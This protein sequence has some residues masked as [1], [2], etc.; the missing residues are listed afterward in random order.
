M[1]SS[2]KGELKVPFP[3]CFLGYGWYQGCGET[4]E[5]LHFGGEVPLVIR[6]VFLTCPSWSLPQSS[7][8]LPGK[9]LSQLSQ[10]TSVLASP[11]FL[12]ISCPH[13][14]LPCPLYLHQEA[15]FFL[16]PGCQNWEFLTTE[17]WVLCFCSC[18][19]GQHGETVA[20]EGASLER[21]LL[22]YCIKREELQAGYL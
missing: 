16:P 1:F 22:T 5:F 8:V 12:A 14:V 9:A 7:Q 11:G 13:L 6:P 15:V 20:R 21:I 3:R 17:G 2:S 10:V 19:L 4:E 18:V